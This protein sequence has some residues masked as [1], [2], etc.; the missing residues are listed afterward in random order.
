MND[1]TETT[2]SRPEPGSA[3]A[4]RI[5]PA[6]FARAEAVVAIVLALG[7]GVYAIVRYTSGDTPT[8]IRL[9]RSD[10]SGLS[11]RSL[12]SKDA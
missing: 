6:I 7:V 1:D 5:A 2:T 11:W 12:S 10:C 3:P 4:P 8:P 9:A